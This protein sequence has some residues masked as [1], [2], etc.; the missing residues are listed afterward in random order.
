MTSA[1]GGNPL[2]ES[3]S[4]PCRLLSYHEP[5]T[6]KVTKGEATENHTH[7]IDFVSV[8][9]IKGRSIDFTFASSGGGYPQTPTD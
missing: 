1:V 9:T 4:G 7:Q 3:I 2:P 8:R 5:N 6:H